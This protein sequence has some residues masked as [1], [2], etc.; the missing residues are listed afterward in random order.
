MYLKKIFVWHLIIPIWQL[1]KSS[2]EFKLVIKNSLCH[3]MVIML[4]IY[5]INNLIVGKSIFLSIHPDPQT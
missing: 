5:N 4:L 3:R 2:D 1:Y